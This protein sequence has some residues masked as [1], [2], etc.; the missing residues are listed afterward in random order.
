MIPSFRWFPYGLAARAA[1]FLNFFNKFSQVATS[2]GF[3]AAD[4]TAVENDNQVMQF[5]SDTVV[6]LE[7]YEEAVKQYRIVITEQPIGKNTPE[8]PANPSFTLP[9]EVPTGIFERLNDLVDRIRVAPGYTDE[10]GA[11]LGILPSSPDKPAPETLKPVATIV[12]AFGGYKFTVHATRMGMPAYKAQ[13]RRMD[14][15]AWTDAGFSTTADLEVTVQPT[16]AGQTE[17]LQVRVIL[18]K[19]NQPVGEPSDA[20]YVTV[21]P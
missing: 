8:F 18:L 19:N 3:T 16:V 11:L 10:I 15:E 4:V 21:N 17:R 1:W 6:Q 5:L 2:L 13:I 20:V 7:A 9:I 12:P 14:S